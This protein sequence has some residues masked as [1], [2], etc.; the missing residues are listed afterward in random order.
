M[1][2]DPRKR[3]VAL[4]CPD[5]GASQLL[6]P[7]TEMLKAEPLGFFPPAGI[8]LDEIVPASVTRETGPPTNGTVKDDWRE[9]PITVGRP[10][11]FRIS[12]E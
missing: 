12:A 11:S 7:S 1:R 9:P 10:T 3:V 8:N 4:E 6:S 2:F 5:C